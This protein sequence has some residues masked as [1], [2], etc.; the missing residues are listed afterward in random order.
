MSFSGLLL[1]RCRQHKFSACLA[2]GVF[3]TVLVGVICTK[4][5]GGEPSLFIEQRTHDFGVVVPGSEVKATFQLCNIGKQ[6]LRIL[7]VVKSC[8]CTTTT[9][10]TSK[11]IGPEEEAS[12]DV[13]LKVP[14][15]MDPIQH[16]ILLKTNDPEHQQVALRLR[17]KPLWPVFMSPTT[18]RL[19]ILRVGTTETRDLEVYSPRGE[20]FKIISIS[21]SRTSIRTETVSS[22]PQRYR[23]NLFVHPTEAGSFNESIEIKTDLPGGYRLHVP[24]VGQVIAGPRFSPSRL[25]LGNRHPGEEV[26]IV[27]QISN[28]DAA[29]GVVAQNASEDWAITDDPT[30]GDLSGTLE[31]RLQVRVP[32]GEGFHRTVLK[33]AT[34]DGTELAQIPSSCYVVN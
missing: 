1:R 18:I 12:L 13:N 31:V 10:F 23:V 25:L 4:K 16:L 2:V 26:K 17:A 7:D 19:P 9:D 34:K 32:T 29:S 21:A 8:G 33:F 11:T 6:D 5:T 20:D 28:I 22:A 15:N 14:E 3:A 24:I 30:I 27:V